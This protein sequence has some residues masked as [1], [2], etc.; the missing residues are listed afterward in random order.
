[1]PTSLYI[2][3]KHLASLRSRLFLDRERARVWHT[4]VV[5]FPFLEK[6]D[7]PHWGWCFKIHLISSISSPYHA[8]RS[9]SLAIAWTR[10]LASPSKSIWEKFS[11]EHSSITLRRAQLFATMG[12]EKNGLDQLRHAMTAP[13]ELLRSM[14]QNTK[15]KRGRMAVKIDISRTYDRVEWS[16]LASEMKVLGFVDSWI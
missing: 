6:K 8:K 9:C 5:Q 12:W 15:G 1:M 14:K 13:H 4:C 10:T 11:S 7:R 3:I 2:Y 16:F